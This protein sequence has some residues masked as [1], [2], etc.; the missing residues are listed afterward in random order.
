MAYYPFEEHRPNFIFAFNPHQ[1]PLQC[2]QL[3]VSSVS[4]IVFC[5]RKTVVSLRR[6]FG[7]TNV[8]ELSSMLRWVVLLFLADSWNDVRHRLENF[9]RTETEARYCY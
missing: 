8:V 7:L 6:T 4:L 5:R 3:I 9:L 2:P 1:L